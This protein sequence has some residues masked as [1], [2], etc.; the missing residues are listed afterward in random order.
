[1]RT[2]SK[3]GRVGDGGSGR[4]V[5]SS[6]IAPLIYFLKYFCIISINKL[7]SMGFEI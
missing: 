2:G 6:F 7:L 5:E 3:S 1:M 4:S